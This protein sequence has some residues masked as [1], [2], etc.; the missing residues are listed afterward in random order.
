MAPT[1]PQEISFS[2]QK[3]L[4]KI[5]WRT[6]I[7]QENSLFWDSIFIGLFHGKAYKISNFSNFHSFCVIFFLRMLQ[8]FS[9]VRISTKKNF[10]THPK[11]F[12]LIKIAQKWG[13]WDKIAFFDRFCEFS[14]KI[15][16]EKVVPHKKWDKKVWSMTPRRLID[17]EILVKTPYEK[18]L[19]WL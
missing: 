6:Q 17:F 10:W 8:K 9:I 13:L 2:I 18:M 19:F 7:F 1:N 14:R 12:F 11:N 5:D 4:R 3:S 16:L 15:V